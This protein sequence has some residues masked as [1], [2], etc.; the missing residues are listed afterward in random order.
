[1][2]RW[3]QWEPMVYSTSSRRKGTSA[4]EKSARIAAGFARAS[5]T[6]VLWKV[7]FQPLYS[8]SWQGLHH[9]EPRYRFPSGAR[10]LSMVRPATTR[11]DPSGDGGAGFGVMTAVE[12]GAGGAEGA[13]TSQR[14]GAGKAAAMNPAN[15]KAG[16]KRR[17]VPKTAS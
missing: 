4:A 15:A 2:Y 1:M 3:S 8:S 10:L 5:W 9:S 12:V 14:P 17:P 16:K 11:P 13:G 7:F 6:A